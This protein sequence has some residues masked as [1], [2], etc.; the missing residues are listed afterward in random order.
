MNGFLRPLIQK[1]TEVIEIHLFDFCISSSRFVYYGWFGT[2]IGIKRMQTKIRNDPSKHISLLVPTT[3]EDN[4]H[5]FPLHAVLI[6]THKNWQENNF[7]CLLFTINV[8]EDL[9]YKQ[10]ATMHDFIL[11][12]D[13]KELLIE[14]VVTEHSVYRTN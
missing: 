5:Y 11:N 7:L 9:D 13:N 6:L 12:I 8:S 14:V 10:P 1:S 2:K 3:A 4:A